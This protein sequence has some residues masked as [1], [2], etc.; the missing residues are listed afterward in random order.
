MMSLNS[1]MDKKL[2]RLRR[3]RKYY[4]ARVDEAAKKAM[5]SAQYARKKAME[6]Q[7]EADVRENK[8]KNEVIRQLNMQIE[9]TQEG[10]KEEAELMKRVKRLKKAMYG[11]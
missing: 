4:K 2:E 8:S 9:K 5:G 10:S 1:D 11:R 7:K 6:K 3:S